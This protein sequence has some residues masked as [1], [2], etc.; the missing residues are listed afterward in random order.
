MSDMDDRKST[1]GSL[2]VCNGGAVSW[3]S[4]KQTVIVD[5]TM[6]VEYIT[7]SEATKEAF[8]YK[9][10]TIEI[11][12]MPSDAIPLYCDNNGAIALAKEPRSHQKF[13]HIDQRF[14]LICDYFEKGYVEVKRVNSID[15]VADPLTKPLGQ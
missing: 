11:G 14:H 5:S 9:K 3:K 7:A 15:N 10:F 4:F 13:K 8:W 6:K 12:V 2:F 1:F